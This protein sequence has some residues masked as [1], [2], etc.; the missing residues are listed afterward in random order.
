MAQLAMLTALFVILSGP[1]KWGSWPVDQAQMVSSIGVPLSPY[2]FILVI[3]TLQHV[4]QLA[5]E[6]GLLSPLR[7]RMARLRLSLYADDA[8]VFINPM[9]VDVDMVMQIMQRFG[10]ATGFVSMYIRAVLHLSDVLRSTWVK[11]CRTSL[12]LKFNSRLPISTCYYAS[13]SCVWC[14][15]S[16]SSTERLTNCQV[17]KAS[18]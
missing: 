2:L 11:Y 3:D 7:D 18:L 6:E 12:V 15:C 16:L 4:L 17:G 9:K 8:T 14:T 1:T 13:V 5:T 10:D